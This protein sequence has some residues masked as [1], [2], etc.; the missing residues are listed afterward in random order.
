MLQCNSL[1][2]SRK[3]IKKKKLMILQVVW[4]VLLLGALLFLHLSVSYIEAHQT[5]FLVEHIPLNVIMT[6]FFF[7]W[8]TFSKRF[9]SLLPGICY[10]N[11]LQQ[12][13]Y[14][15]CICFLSSGL[16]DLNCSHSVRTQFKLVLAPSLQ[17]ISKIYRYPFQIGFFYLIICI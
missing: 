12:I 6:R 9:F 10:K 15:F 16:S 3:R 14:C 5:I 7:E 8:F 4:Y 2:G 11:V 13:I 17:L 1:I